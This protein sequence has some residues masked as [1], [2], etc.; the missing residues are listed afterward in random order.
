MGWTVQYACTATT[1]TKAASVTSPNSPSGS[2]A[3]STIR[4]SFAALIQFDNCC[5]ARSCCRATSATTAPGATACATMRPF[6]SALQRRRRATPANLRASSGPVPCFISVEHNDVHLADSGAKL[7]TDEQH[8]AMAESKVGD[9]HDHRHAA[10]QHDFM[11]P[12]EL[13]GLARAK[14][15]GAWAAAVACPFARG[16]TACRG[17]PSLPLACPRLRR[18]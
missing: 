17:S 12:V 6:S 11:G 5:G 9:L 13:V 7:R 8:P 16:I 3:G 1:G 10:Q 2:G 15:S 18:G 14:P 4:P